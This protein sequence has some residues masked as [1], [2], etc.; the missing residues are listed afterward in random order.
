VALLGEQESERLSITSLLT[1]AYAATLAK[2]L[3]DTNAVTKHIEREL[4]LD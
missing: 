4:N 3:K 2:A 1:N